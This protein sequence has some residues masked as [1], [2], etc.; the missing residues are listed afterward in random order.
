MNWKILKTEED[1]QKA[2]SRLEELFDCKKGE[3]GFDEAELLVVLIE[4]YENE[5][6]PAF[7]DLDPIDLIKSTMESN[8]LKNKD[9]IGILGSKS[10][11][12][13][14]LNRKRRLSLNM[15]R[16]VSKTLK[17]PAELLIEKYELSQ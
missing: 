13:E 11:V 17:I 2:L 3:V 10:K 7:R 8:E 1:Y 15:I 4:K 16:K 5:T 14:V 6:E 12:S 9:L